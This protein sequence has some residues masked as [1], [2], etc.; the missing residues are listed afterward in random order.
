MLETPKR[1]LVVAAHPDDVEM[2]CGGT[3]AKLA[4]QGAQVCL[5][6]VTSGECGGRRNTLTT[7]EMIAQRESEQREAA[8]LLGATGVEFLRQPDGGVEYSLTLRGQIV[9]QVRI[10]QPDALFT[11]DP[12]TLLLDWNEVNHRDHRVVGELAMDAAYPYA[13]GRLL[14]PEQLSAGG[15]SPHAVKDLFLWDSNTPNHLEDITDHM[16]AR[17]NAVACHKTQFPKIEPVAAW[18][19]NHASKVGEQKQM[20]YGECFHRVDLRPVF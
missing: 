1:V 9:R 20:T 8:K 17:I 12:R 10:W 3:I 16:D 2:S 19:R 5:L 15:L 11:H 4:A 13:R 14:Y 6:L 7:E 18:L